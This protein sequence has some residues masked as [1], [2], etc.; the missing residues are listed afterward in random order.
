MISPKKRYA[1]PCVRFEASPVT[2]EIP[3]GSLQERAN[4]VV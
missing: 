4:G 2:L 3:Q 1:L